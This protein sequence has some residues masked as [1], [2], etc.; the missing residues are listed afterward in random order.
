MA[1]GNSAEHGEIMFLLKTEAY[2]VTVS[3]HVDPNARTILGGITAVVKWEW[4]ACVVFLLA[5]AVSSSSG[6][7]SL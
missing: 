2:T 3:F 6:M 7:R 4:D 1:G 5:C